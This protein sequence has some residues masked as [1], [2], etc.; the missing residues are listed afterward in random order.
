[1][2]CKETGHLGKF[3]NLHFTHQI[4]SSCCFTDI[5]TIPNQHYASP[6]SK[7]VRLL[8]SPRLAIVNLRVSVLLKI[9]GNK[10]V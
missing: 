5:D 9:P 1:M 7:C 2:D 10:Y 4:V 8:Q 3:E 6:L